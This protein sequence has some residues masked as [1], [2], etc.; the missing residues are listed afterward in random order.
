MSSNTFN[1]GEELKKLP[2]KPGVYI[3]RGAGDEIIY[4]GKA[5]NLRSRVRQYFQPSSQYTNLKVRNL[6]PNIAW[7]EY[8]VTDSELEALIL[9]NNLIKKHH[10]RYNVRLKDDKSYAY[11]KLTLGEAFPRLFMTR[12][13]KKDKSKYFGPFATKQ[14]REEVLDVAHRV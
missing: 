9:E 6:A 1:I 13:H 4:I 10:P 8:I 11:I 2:Q 7:F 14:S 12:N 5:I 3:M